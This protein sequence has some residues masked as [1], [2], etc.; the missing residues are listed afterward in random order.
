M[1]AFAMSMKYL[2]GT[3]DLATF[4]RDLLA[5]RATLDAHQTESDASSLLADATLAAQYSQ[6]LSTLL[7]DQATVTEIGI[8]NNLV[9]GFLSNVLNDAA[10]RL[11]VLDEQLRKEYTVTFGGSPYFGFYIPQLTFTL[12]Y[13]G[14]PR[15]QNALSQKEKAR[16][17]Y[18]EAATAAA[19]VS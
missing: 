18:N 16:S 7:N 14:D 13:T 2:D 1:R 10:D 6:Q 19:P 4:N 8:R 3:F 9:V 11:E 15:Y 12:N 17:A 5:T